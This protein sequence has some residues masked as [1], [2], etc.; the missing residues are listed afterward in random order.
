M[1]GTMYLQPQSL[2]ACQDSGSSN[3]NVVMLCDLLLQS[4]DGNSDRD[5]WIFFSSRGSSGF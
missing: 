2:R 3:D 1:I 4:G 5:H